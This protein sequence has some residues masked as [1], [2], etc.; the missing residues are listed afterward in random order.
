VE[1]EDGILF[2]GNL[3]N[4]DPYYSEPG[5]YEEYRVPLDPE[6]KIT[7]VIVFDQSSNVTSVTFSK[8]SNDYVYVFSSSTG[9]SEVIEYRDLVFKA[10]Q[11]INVALLVEDDG[12]RVGG[13]ASMP[14]N[15]FS[16]VS[17]TTVIE[18]DGRIFPPFVVYEGTTTITFAADYSQTDV[19]GATDPA[20]LPEGSR[21]DVV[22][23]HDDLVLPLATGTELAPNYPNPFNPSTT[24]QFSVMMDGPAAL[25]VYNTIGQEVATLFDGYALSGRFYTATFDASQLPSGFYYARLETAG[26]QMVRKMLLVK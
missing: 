6:G 20:V 26:Q 22:R 17:W 5:V 19:S 12:L 13:N 14:L 24:L 25:R 1:T 18:G 23:L 15:E 8:Y 11:F 3:Q 7:A 9:Q 10:D 16:P 21:R 4:V 2:Q